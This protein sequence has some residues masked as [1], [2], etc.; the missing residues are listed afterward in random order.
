M[1][2]EMMRGRHFAALFIGVFLVLA[3]P[4][5]RAQ[6][7]DKKQGI[8]VLP[9]FLKTELIQHI[10]PWDRLGKF[11]TDRFKFTA[12]SKTYSFQFSN[13]APT[14]LSGKQF[15]GLPGG[16][17]LAEFRLTKK[18]GSLSTFRSTGYNRR[19]VQSST[20]RKLTGLALA[21]PKSFWGAQL[22]GYFLQASPDKPAK[23]DPATPGKGAQ[24]GFTFA[25]NFKK[26]FR[27]Q[28]ELSQFWQAVRSPGKQNEQ[29]RGLFTQLTGKLAGADMSATYRNQGEG[30]VNPAIPVKGRGR[31]LFAVNVRR[32]HK[33]LQFEY[34]NQ[35]DSMAESRALSLASLGIH[36]ESVRWTYSPKL[37][38]QFSAIGMWIRQELA[39]KPQSENNLRFSANKGLKHFTLG[40]AYLRGSRIDAMAFQPLWDTWGLIGDASME[41][42]KNRRLNFHYETNNLTL[43]QTS[44]LLFTQTLQCNTRLS[45]LADAL[46][47]VPAVDYRHQQDNLGKVNF[48]LVNFVLSAIVKLPRYVP[49]TEVLLTFSSHHLSAL[50]QQ[51][52]NS[53]G[54]VLQWNFK[55]L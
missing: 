45:F 14:L 35:A 11:S 19:F 52:Q 12:G 33:K 5:L 7:Q 55:R 2:F 43:H 8:F 39:G 25:K 38:P 41:I 17:E 48:S 44:Q 50:G 42:Q 6:S 26:N 20:A 49:G 29:T 23:G 1:G 32:T 24:T 22:S 31:G 28:T 47:F 46:A 34:V 10:N 16:Y 36:T 37:W 9:S 13:E 53:A 15:L 4:A 27:L 18:W 54:F 21:M 51:Q 40:M 3:C 30:F